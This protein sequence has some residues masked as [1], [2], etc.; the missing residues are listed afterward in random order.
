MPPP[1]RASR[2]SSAVPAIRRALAVFDLLANSRRGLT[3]SEISRRLELPKSSTHRI[4]TTLE[5]EQCIYKNAQTGRYYFGT[6]LFRLYKSTL[7]GVGLREEAKPILVALMQ[8][9]GMTV[10]M[11]VLDHGQAVVIDKLSPPG[12]P[13]I[14][15]WIGRAMDVNST[16]VGKALIAFL[17]PE[18]LAREVT[19]RTFVRHN[20]FTITSMAKLKEELARVRERGYS[21]DDE[22]DEL[23]ARCV[24]APVF[25]GAKVIAAISIVGGTDDLPQERIPSMGALVR[26]TAAAIS[27]RLSSNRTHLLQK[28]L[29]PESEISPLKADAE[30]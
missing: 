30:R 23:G 21:V 26:R 19:V 7:E 11:A 12:G 1:V 24:G 18:E 4:L 17:S 10:H 8:K 27:A 22:E 25:S 9:T 29:D 14:G 16:A 13:N 20:R 5:D 6:K 2:E 3:V 15:T 28:F